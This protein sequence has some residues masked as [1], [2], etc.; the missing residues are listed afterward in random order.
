MTRRPT[1]LTVVV[2]TAL[3]TSAFASAS[4][5]EQQPPRLVLVDDT[6][7]LNAALAART[8][9]R[10]V[11]VRVAGVSLPDPDSA[12]ARLVILAEIAGNEA[13]T[14]RRPAPTTPGGTPPSFRLAS[15]AYVVEDER[16]QAVA[17][18]FR[19]GELPWMPTGTLGFSE[20]VTLPPGAYVL[21]LAAL[22]NAK[23]G[24]AQA[25]L[26]VRVQ[27]A[28]AVR[29]GDLV[30]GETT[31][32]DI[33]SGLA[34]DA[35]IRGDRL[36]ASMA[37]ATAGETPPEGLA[38]TVE[39]A[40]DPAGPAMMTAPALLPVDPASGLRIARS[41]V[42]VRALPPGDYVARAIVS[43]AGKEA[44]RSVSPFRHEA[45]VVTTSPSAPAAPRS[46]GAAATPVTAVGFRAEDVLDAGVLRPFL[47]DL[48]LRAANRSKA[49]IEQAKAGRFTEAAKTAASADAS[50]PAKPFLEGL[51]LFSQK[52]LQAASEAFR[53][54]L[55]TAPDFFVGA[56]YIGACYAAGG[57]DPQAVNAW[58]TS[59][60]GLDQYPIVFRLL[61]DALTR[62]GQPERA[63]ETL[64]EAVAKWPDDRPVR[65]RTA[66]AALDARRYDRVFALVDDAPAAQP[67]PEL[68]FTGM[69]AVY[70]QAT[71]RPG[72]SGDDLVARARRYRDAYIAAG[73]T[74]QAL[75]A[76]WAAAVERKK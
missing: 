20:T 67:S 19:R 15:V 75:V 11:A 61:A 5:V 17:R 29:F 31:G 33:G 73:G 27:A 10:D 2:A 38:V 3:G 39:V 13:S 32:Q 69:Q 49:A 48:A 4:A 6:A 22:R 9:P 64:E 50:D 53:E 66:R 41:V 30:L 70:E 65:V 7:E 36:V 12:K 59:L 62:M 47:D 60:V 28:G 54:T 24:A 42:D 1:L 34:F 76:E 40:K 56:F 44:G 46:G 63:L 23:V 18:G 37:V 35:A 26:A 58:Q 57:R 45:A 43:V 14:G 8:P 52:Q 25:R 16:G 51:S 21:K 71:Q 55:R 68:A 74:Q 72:S